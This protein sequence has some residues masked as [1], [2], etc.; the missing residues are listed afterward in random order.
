MLTLRGV[1]RTH[2]VGDAQVVALQDVSLTIADNDFVAIVG[3]SGSGK[4]TLLQIIGLLDRPTAGTVELDGQDLEALSDDER[5]SLRLRTIG[6]VFQRFH[7]L[8][9]I[10]ALE[11]VALPMEAAGLPANERYERAAKLLVAVG[12]GDRLHFQPPRLS[13]GQRQRVAIA[14]ALANGPK[15]LL[16]DEPT[17][18]LHSEDRAAVVSLFR[19]VH[20]Q[21]CAVVI[22]T[23]DKEVAAVTQRQ[24]DIRD[25]RV[26]SSEV[27]PESSARSLAPA[28]EPPTLV[29]TPPRGRRG[30]WWRIALV[31][32]VG[33]AGLIAAGLLIPGQLASL[34]PPSVAPTPEAAANRVARGAVHPEREAR[35]R[36]SA[37]AVVNSLTVSVGTSVIDNQELVRLRAADG[38]ISVVTAPWRGT[39]TSLPIHVGDSVTAGGLLATVG[40]LSRLQVETTDVDEFLVP[41][42]HLGQ[43]VRLTIDALP[44]REFTGTVSSLAYQTEETPEGDEHYPVSIDFDW[45]APEIR[46]GMTVRVYFP[47]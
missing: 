40:D 26:S 42:V 6:F 36:A 19:E 12:L 10:S 23:H 24:I 5:A 8:H 34:A 38:S 11:N 30:G 2:A 20:R 31:L 13:G 35:I 41:Y 3:P 7:L 45:A 39:V 15:I 44:D 47:S 32:A 9:D 17:G 33:L 27:G 37:P 22:V 16:A 46:P 18:E 4:S 25:G 28:P 43:S 1:W 29:P 21:G 14:R